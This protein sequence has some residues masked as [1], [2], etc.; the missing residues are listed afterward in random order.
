[1]LVVFHPDNR[2]YASDAAQLNFIGFSENGEYLA[3]EQYGIQDGSGFA[4]TEIIMVNV[5]KNSYACPTIT[6]I[7]DEEHMTLAITRDSVL[8]KARSK[9]KM[10]SI[11]Q[12]NTGEH[13]IHHPLSDLE[14][15][16]KHVR[17]YE[18]AGGI[19]ALSGLREY[20]LTLNEIEVSNDNNEY[21]YGFGPPK[22]LE[23]IINTPGVDE[24]VVLQ[25]DT[26]LPKRRSNV[27]YYRIQDVYI[28]HC[29]GQKYIAVFICYDMPGFEGSDLRFMVVTA[30]L[31]L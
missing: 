4:Y 2:L 9:L 26:K 27:L 25:R 16:P 23:L 20:A 31:D 22:M 3:F 18:Q 5:P 15:D 14:A 13:V 24:K 21:G 11:V 6:C 28:Y 19:Q 12:G 10:L 30:R 1:M 7:G 17:F 29:A 8:T